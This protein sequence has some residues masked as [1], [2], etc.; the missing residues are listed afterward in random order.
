MYENRYKVTA[1]VTTVTGK[2][3]EIETTTRRTEP[4]LHEFMRAC[5]AA[6]SNAKYIYGK[7]HKFVGTT[8]RWDEDASE[9]PPYYQRLAE[10]QNMPF[11]PASTPMP[12][13]VSSEP[14]L[15]E[16]KNVAGV[17][18]IVKHEKELKTWDEAIEEFKEKVG[19]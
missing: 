7:N 6:L 1:K 12:A 19:A 2:V 3:V 18:T 14:Q 17:Y 8:W 5:G 10:R 13:T 15:Y 4:T 9:L 16:I 11:V